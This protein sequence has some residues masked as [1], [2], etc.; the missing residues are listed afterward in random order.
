MTQQIDVEALKAE[1]EMLSDAPEHHIETISQQAIA[2]IEQLQ[3]EN[4]ELRK[5]A[6]RYRYMRRSATSKYRNGPGLYW[7]LP[8]YMQG[9]KA[10]QLDAS[11]DAAMPKGG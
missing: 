2:A 7:H 6:E 9:S 3:A 1:L 8:R 10:E 5:D 11:I 4:A